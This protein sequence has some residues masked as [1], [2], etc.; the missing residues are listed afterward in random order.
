MAIVNQEFFHQE[1]ALS[2]STITMIVPSEPFEH[3][4]IAIANLI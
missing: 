1:D 4:H 2:L 3:I